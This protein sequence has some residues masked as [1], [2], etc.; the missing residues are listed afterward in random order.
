MAF[1]ESSR[2]LCQTETR[3]RTV[4]DSLPLQC[5]TTIPGL[6]DSHR[7]SQFNICSFL[8]SVHS[9][10]S[11]SVENLNKSHPS[12]DESLGPREGKGPANGHIAG[13]QR[14][15][16]HSGATTHVTSRFPGICKSRGK[17]A[18]MNPYDSLYTLGSSRLSELSPPPRLSHG[19]IGKIVQSSNQVYN[20]TL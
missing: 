20:Y 7:G 18:D 13:Y 15:S 11:L 19:I 12:P 16:R 14:R 3:N 4:T 6:P 8:I 9:V 2:P 1:P 5:G 17:L 10:S